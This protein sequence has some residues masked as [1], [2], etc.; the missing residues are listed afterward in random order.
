[1]RNFLDFISNDVEVKKTLLSSL[2]TKT[3]TNI[4]KYNGTV[5]EFIGKYTSYKESV[6]QY[7]KAKNNTLKIKAEIKDCSTYDERITSLERLRELFNPFNTSYEK[8]GFDELIYRMS[9]YY[10]FN[11]DSIDSII[12]EFFDKFEAAGIYLKASDFDYTYYVHRYME[13]FLEVRHKCKTLED[14]NRTFEEVYWSNP[15]IISHIEINFRKLINRYTKK[16]DAYITKQQRENAS[17]FNIKNY[18]EC[19]NQL[20]DAYFAKKKFLEEDISDIINKAIN[21]EFDISQ[22]LES[23]KFRKS[24]Y[25]SFVNESVDVNDNGIMDKLCA[26][27]SKLSNNLEEYNG[28]LL[29]EPVI[30]DFKKK[31]DSLKDKNA[32]N[33]VE[34]KTTL[35]TIKKQEA[36]LDKLNKKIFKGSLDKT[37]RMESISRTKK[38]YDLYKKYDE[39]YFKNK[40][41]SILNI[42]MSISDVLDLYYSFDQFKK[43]TIQKVYGLKTYDEVIEKSN[44]FDT[45]AKNPT[46][47]IV[48][49]LPVFEDNNIP[50]II[51]NKYK[52]NN[53]GISEDDIMLDNIPVLN[54]KI[55]LITRIYKINLST[56]SVEKIWFMVNANKIINKSN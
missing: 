53:I 14:L 52:L 6:Y 47:I 32:S 7:I 35:A 56:T 5:D 24:A 42:N 43:L 41:L 12:N 40:V 46:N 45:F 49:G 29:I 37:L 4:K 10:V 54:S 9:N 25:S 13:E 27:L 36:E 17:K 34:L 11:F 39:E 18:N 16:F 1:M 15:D 48:K 20:T 19:I 51:A 55:A 23:S 26:S 22:Y 30:N 33:A 3:K 38:L 8:M 21:K 31:Y 50:R 44:I 28:Y 2:P